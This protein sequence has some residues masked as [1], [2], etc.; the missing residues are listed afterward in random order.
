M[1]TSI[2]TVVQKI[3]LSTPT[4]SISF[5]ASDFSS[6]IDTGITS[7]G[8]KN[9]NGVSTVGQGPI[10]ISLSFTII[11]KSDWSNSPIELIKLQNSLASGF[12]LQVTGQ[13]PNNTAG[14]VQG[15]DYIYDGAGYT[16]YTGAYFQGVNNTYSGSNVGESYTVI[17]TEKP[18]IIPPLGV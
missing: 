13:K 9:A 6:S 16:M 3:T 18:D 1:A 4:G 8:D 17:C 2:A 11:Q 15:E 12:T 14:I 10:V 7:V 5:L